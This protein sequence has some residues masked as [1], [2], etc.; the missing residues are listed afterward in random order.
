VNATLHNRDFSLT[1]WCVKMM[2]QTDIAKPNALLSALPRLTAIENVHYDT[3]FLIVFI[4][5]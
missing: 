5:S 3:L 4:R 1:I 2:M